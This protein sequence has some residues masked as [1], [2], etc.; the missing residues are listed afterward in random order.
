MMW[1]Y[2]KAATVYALTMILSALASRYHL[3]TD[4]S[5]LLSNDVWAVAAGIAALFTG[6]GGVYL[7]GQAAK[8]QPPNQ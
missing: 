1:E 4:Q 2:S 7:H 6:A 5:Q 3:T 8:M